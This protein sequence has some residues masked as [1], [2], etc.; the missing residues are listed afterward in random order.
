LKSPVSAVQSLLTAMREGYAGSIPPRQQ[1]ILAR[2]INKQEQLLKLIRDLLNLAEG[3]TSAEGQKRVAVFIDAAAAEAVKLFEAVSTQ[4]GVAVV[5]LPPKRPIPFEEIPGDL[6]RLFSNLLDNAIRY[7]PP[8]GKVEIETGCDDRQITI[9]LKDNG[10]G[11]EPEYR[12]KI[13]EEF[14]RTP[15]AKKC[16]AEGTG[17]GL[18]IVMGIVNRYHGSIHLESEPGKGSAFLI[19]FPKRNHKL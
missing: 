1:D 14:F 15:R 2:C 3:K 8:G 17:L 11:I 9:T 7:T 13:F 16:L 4:K 5:S 19:T 18:A 12:E 6:Q 10:I